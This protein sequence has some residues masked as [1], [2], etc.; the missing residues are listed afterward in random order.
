[1]IYRW[2]M[3]V[4]SIGISVGLVLG[5]P[6][7][8]HADSSD[9]PP[10]RG[11]DAVHS[12]KGQAGAEIDVEG[13]EVVVSGDRGELG[14]QVPGSASNRRVDLAGV[15]AHLFRGEGEPVLSTAVQ[16]A[17][18]TTF[19]TPEGAQTLIQIASSAASR[20]YRFPLDI[21]AGGEA[22][23]ASDGSVIVYGR[24]GEVVGSYATPWAIDANGVDVPT[25]FRLEGNVLVQTV[26]FT[27]S[28]VFP[29]T[30]D[31]DYG[32][33]WWGWYIRWTKAETKRAASVA[34]DAQAFVGVLS[35]GCG[36][37]P[38]PA[39]PACGIIVNASAWGWAWRVRDA[40]ARGKCLALNIPWASIANPYVFQWNVTT[41]TC[42]R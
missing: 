11:A 21:P 41:V 8:S 1:M 39:G 23:L 6:V 18:L 4:A 29:V 2:G 24:D 14:M 15:P 19:E 27:A 37:I 5:I 28:T 35:G 25:D 9:H 30:A 42:T 26:R 31:P 34:G 17:V 12:P 13:T 40:A 32:T 7:A 22:A 3:R 36:F 16:E 20:E 10:R 33:V 38:V